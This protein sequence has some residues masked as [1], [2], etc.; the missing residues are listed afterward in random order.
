M[1]P[2]YNAF[3]DDQEQAITGRVLPRAASVMSGNSGLTQNVAQGAAL[4]GYDEELTRLGKEREAAQARLREMRDRPVDYTQLQELAKQRG[5]EGE[6]AMLTALAAQFAGPQYQGLQGA[7]LKRSMSAREPIKTA[8]GMVTAEGFVGDPDALQADEVRRAGEDAQ[9][10]E[11]QYGRVLTATQRAAERRE[12]ERRREEEKE[13]DRQL[14]RELPSLV[15]AARGSGGGGGAQPVTIMVG[16]KPMVV[17]ART[18]AVIG[19]APPTAQTAPKPLPAAA[20]RIQ[21]EAIEQMVPVGGLNNRIDRLLADIG[22]TGNLRLGLIQN[23]VNRALNATGVSTPQSQAYEDL[24]TNLETFRNG[25]LML[26]KG[27]QT[28]GDAQRAMNQIVQSINDPKVVSQALRRL[29]ELNDEAIGLQ[30]T[31]VNTVR[32]EYGAEPMNFAPIVGNTGGLPTPGVISGGNRSQPASNAGGL[33]PQEQAEM[34]DLRKR[35]SKR[36]GQ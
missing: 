3:R 36:P 15:A 23:Q 13:R 12:Q 25:I 14:R 4:G 17:D 28:E 26:H 2:I 10:A 32:R 30:Q 27:V 24:K 6:D 8:R 16:G 34:E 35:F 33:T 1:F 9:F 31:R 5:M 18:R 7:L 19:E 11:Q 29:R 21:D 20:L 22:P